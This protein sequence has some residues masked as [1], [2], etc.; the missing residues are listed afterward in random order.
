MKKI[1]TLLVAVILLTLSASPALGAPKAKVE[2]LTKKTA[3]IVE[4]GTSWVA[5]SWTA[6]KADATDFR[7]VAKSNTRGVT[8]AYPTT[9]GDHTSLMD[10]DTLSDGEIDYT[11]LQISVPYGSKDVKLT[12][13]ATWTSDGKT[14]NKNYKVKVPVAK[15]NGEDIAQSTDHAGSV[16]VGTPVWLGVDWTGIAPI[17]EDVQ[18]TVSS[19]DGAVITYPENTGTYT[20]LHYNDTLDAGETDVA[21]FLVDASNMDPGTYTLNLELSYTKGTDNKSVEG[22]VSFEVTGE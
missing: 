5:L 15:F 17:V 2:L 1:F 9:T 20:S 7:V 10:N 13:E 22:K 18:M 8:I 6:K 11:S 4:G 19:P 16:P 21:R 3:A 12:V 14:K